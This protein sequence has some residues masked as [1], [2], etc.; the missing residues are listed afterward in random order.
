M[1][2]TGPPVP[3]CAR[4]LLLGA[5]AALCAC[6]PP[7]PAVLLI[8]S[9]DTLRADHVGRR[10]ARGEPL[11]PTL[12]ALAAQGLRFS[13]ASAQANES[14]FSHRSIFMGA[15]ASAQGALRYDAPRLPADAPT[16]AAAFAEAGWTTEAFVG[17]GHLAPSFGLDGG[18]QRYTSAA[19]F[20]GLQATVPL[21]IPALEAAA[22]ADRPALIFVHGYDLHSPYAPPGPFFASE[23][24]E[25]QGPLRLEVDD[26][27]LYERVWGEA[28]YPTFRPPQ[29]VREDGV[30]VM[31]VEAYAALAAHAE[32]PSSPR[33]PLSPADLG[34]VRGQYAAAAALADHHLGR[35]LRAAQEAGLK[36]RL[37]IVIFADHGEDL[38][39]HGTFNHRHVLADS[40]L[41]VPLLVVGP[42]IAAGEEPAPV[43]LS[44]LRAAL[45]ARYGLRDRAPGSRALPL[46]GEPP[47]PGPVA[48]ESMRGERSLRWADRR[49]SA[50][51]TA[52][53]GPPP[54]QAPPGAV[55][56]DDAGQPILWPP[57][58]EDW[59]AL[60]G[61][62]W[63]ADAP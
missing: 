30:Q 27:L 19:P 8:I 34:F 2:P 32:D 39:E 23:T 46:K 54:T 60:R 44:G 52:V 63:T 62:P 36:E 42:G 51:T 21:A 35:L 58:P 56:E 57:S 16:L 17:G 50:P 24:P 26:P 48:S 28:L 41:R 13:R 53:A 12:D 40:T 18:F 55:Y 6:A 33:V 3:R 9:L 37:T 38:G 31:P 47:P 49:L 22:R 20:S 59:A 11:T 61:P 1:R 14:L 4:G 7:E 10:D 45:T 5:S 29:S 43:G 25:Y 15:L